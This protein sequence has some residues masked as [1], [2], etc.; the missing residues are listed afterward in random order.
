MGAREKARLVGAGPRGRLERTGPS[1]RTGRARDAPRAVVARSRATRWTQDS[2]RRRPRPGRRQV[3]L[4]RLRPPRP[5]RRRGIEIDGH[6]SPRRSSSVGCVPS[7]QCARRISANGRRTVARRTRR[8]P[9]GAGGGEESDDLTVIGD[10][11]RRSRSN[12]AQDLRTA[13]AQIT[14]RELLGHVPLLSA[15]AIVARHVGRPREVLQ[16]QAAYSSSE[17]WR[18]EAAK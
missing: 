8:R 7:E 13:I 15:V 12:F 10:L 17:C 4:T 3:P 1:Q 11:V 6:R 16:R 5:W 14:V 18:A 2:A 9:S